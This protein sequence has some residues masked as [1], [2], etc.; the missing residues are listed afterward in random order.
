MHL[1]N[2]QHLN[3]FPNPASDYLNIS[4]T[5]DLELKEVSVYNTLGQRLMVSK[6]DQINVSTLPSGV[7]YLSIETD[8]GRVNKTLVRE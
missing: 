3:V 2:L 5:D 6:Q 8:Q 1:N 4:V 7:Y